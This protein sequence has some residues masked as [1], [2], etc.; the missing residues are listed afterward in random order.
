[1]K[2]EDLIHPVISG[3]KFRKLKY[4]IQSI[5]KKKQLISFGGAYS[6]HLLALSYIGKYENLNTVGIVRGEELKNLELNP[7]LKRCIENGMKLKFVDRNEYRLRNNKVYIKK[8]KKTYMNSLIIP[9]GGTNDKGIKGCEEIL[10]DD[11]RVFFDVICV[12]VGS[13]GTFSGLI[14]SSSKKQLVIGF[15][16]LNN[17]NLKN[18][19]IKFVNKKN[20]ELIEDDVFGGYAKF[21]QELISFINNFY[22]I[23]KIKLDPIYNSKMIFRIIDTIKK[24]KWRFG[25]RIL[26]I[27]TGGL[28]SIESFNNLLKNKKC[29][30]I[31][32]TT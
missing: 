10:S 32:F 30:T 19:I 25:K 13:G 12:P 23:T 29:E 14:N 6:N 3:N 24:K 31:S 1:M 7:T 15:S 9:E 11:D 28:Q 8:L 17:S 16:S 4:N 22:N 2:R 18:D 27:N 20:W 21:N 26:I 5:D